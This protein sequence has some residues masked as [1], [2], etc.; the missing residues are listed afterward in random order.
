MTI[1][2]VAACWTTAGPAEPL[3]P[4][5]RSPVPIRDRVELASAAGFTGFGIRHG[6]LLAVESEMGFSEF[7]RILDANGMKF[8][9][10]EFLEGWYARDETRARSD[11]QRADFLRAAAELGVNLIKVGGN[12]SGGAYDVNQVAE[13]FAILGEQAHRAGAKIGLEPM[14]FADITD[15]AAGLEVV[16]RADHPSAGLFLDLWHIGRAGT[17][18]TSLA[19]I[20]VKCIAGVELADA[21]REVR[22]PLLHDTVNHRRFPGEG[23]LDVAGFVNAVTKTGFSGPWGIEMLSTDYREMP[24]PIAARRAFASAA[25]YLQS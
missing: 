24:V 6:D 21:D 14:P 1:D 3:G 19:D 15:A 20:P 9:D 10:V 2:V 8:L 16:L 18:V 12:L 22:G 11:R 17:D 7:R 13:E 23:V 5:D 4:D 25:A